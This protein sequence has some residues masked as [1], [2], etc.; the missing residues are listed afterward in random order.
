MTACF[1][2]LAEW[3]LRLL[4][5]FKYNQ[6]FQSP[7]YESL[8]PR[9]VLT[10]SSCFLDRK[11]RVP[12]CNSKITLLLTVKFSG[13][14]FFILQDSSFMHQLLLGEH[15]VIFIQ[16]NSVSVYVLRKICMYLSSNGMALR[17]PDKAL[18]K[19]E[20][21]KCTWHENGEGDLIHLFHLVPCLC[22]YSFQNWQPILRF[23]PEWSI[24]NHT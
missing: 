21:N 10:F 6:S 3:Y 8:K 15:Y 14:E 16:T 23:G 19:A 2:H 20:T 4:D 22:L 18:L 17:W 24:W 1:N 5:Y 9:C 13:T 11:G 7:Q 12:H